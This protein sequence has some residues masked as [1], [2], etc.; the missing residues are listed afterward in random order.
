MRTLCLVVLLGG[1]ASGGADPHRSLPPAVPFV[2]MS[3]VWSDAQRCQELVSTGRV[4]RRADGTFRIAVWNVRWF[5]DGS[6][7]GVSRAGGT[8]LDWLACGM[9]WLNADVIAVQEF[10]MH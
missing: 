1:C 4:D 9:A 6:I 8:D 3:P 7:D 2:K 5:P 10:K